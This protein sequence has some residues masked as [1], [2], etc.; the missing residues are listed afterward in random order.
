M[1][2]WRGSES[3]LSAWQM[4]GG[5]QMEGGTK[6]RQ[7]GDQIESRWERNGS[8]VDTNGSKVGDQTKLCVEEGYQ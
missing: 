4:Q 2:M 8:K 5:D 1:G 6:W 3:I 7:G